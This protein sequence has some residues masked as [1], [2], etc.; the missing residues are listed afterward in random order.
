MRLSSVYNVMEQ[1]KLCREESYNLISYLLVRVHS[2]SMS[3]YR[4]RTMTAYVPHKH[5]SPVLYMACVA[6]VPE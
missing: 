1:R 3:V 4:M 6:L 2:P 5:D